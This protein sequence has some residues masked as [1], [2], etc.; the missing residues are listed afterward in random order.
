MDNVIMLRSEGKGRDLE[1]KVIELSDEFSKK[2][3]EI[4][5][6]LRE[7]LEL[8]AA[9]VGNLF[10]NIGSGVIVGVILILLNRLVKLLEGNDDYKKV[11]IYIT[12]SN[13]AFNFPKDT[14]KLLDSCKN[15]DE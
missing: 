13:V 9:G 4:H 12:K 11:N 2:G 3:V 6:A 14:Q 8:G 5:S 1:K 10:I 15:G 7:S